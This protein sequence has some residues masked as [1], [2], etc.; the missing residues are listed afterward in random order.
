[1][2]PSSSLSLFKNIAC[3]LVVDNESARA[4]SAMDDQKLSD[5]VVF[6]IIDVDDVLS[7]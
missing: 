4:M 5:V 3:D 1:M 2:S 6:V 7:K